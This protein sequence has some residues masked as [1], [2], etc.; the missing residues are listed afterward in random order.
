MCVDPDCK[1]TPGLPDR[2]HTQAVS[3]SRIKTLTSNPGSPEC[4]YELL[5]HL[6]VHASQ[7]ADGQ[8]HSRRL[9]SLTYRKISQGE[10]SPNHCEALQN[11]PA[12]LRASC[13]LQGA[14]RKPTATSKI[15]WLKN[16]KKYIFFKVSLLVNYKLDPYFI[17]CT[18]E[19]ADEFELTPDANETINLRIQV[20]II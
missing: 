8:H 5:T 17:P 2:K 16:I 11:R 3:L 19:I 12:H 4:L 10:P 13:V 20:N 7:I 18:K 9:R 15:F 1:M 14:L 6:K